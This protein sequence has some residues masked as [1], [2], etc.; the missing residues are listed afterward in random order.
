[1]KRVSPQEQVGIQ[2]RFGDG[3]GDGLGK[4]IGKRSANAVQAVGVNDDE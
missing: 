2:W 3:H 4:K 1:M